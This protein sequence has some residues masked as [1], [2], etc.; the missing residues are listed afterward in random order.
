MN[1][2][3]LFFSFS[4]PRIKHT[5]LEFDQLLKQLTE[6][7]T[8]M[9]R[10][11]AAS[12]LGQGPHRRTPHGL[13]WPGCTLLA[14][15]G[16]RGAKGCTLPP[17][18][19]ASSQHQPSLSVGASPPEGWLEWNLLAEEGSFTPNTNFYTFKYWCFSGKAPKFKLS[20]SPFSFL[21][22]TLHS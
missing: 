20:P 5:L 12:P 11:V 16:P 17:V 22:L 2:V 1:S 19:W 21:A 3:T 6:P 13:R 7:S 14:G 9:P 10:T 8:S 18:P 4:G 15:S